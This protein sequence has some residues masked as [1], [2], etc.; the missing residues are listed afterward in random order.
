MVRRAEPKD[1][2]RM[3]FHGTE[4]YVATED[5]NVAVNGTTRQ[6]Q[7]LDVGSVGIHHVHLRDATAVADES[8]LLAG[9]GIPRSGSIAAGRIRNSLGAGAGGIDY[10]QLRIAVHAGHEHQL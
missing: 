2:S 9:L 3:R 8:H 4:T 10:E 7:F 1:L 5:L 6:A